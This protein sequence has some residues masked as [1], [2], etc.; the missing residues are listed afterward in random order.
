MKQSREILFFDL[1][2]SLMLMRAF[3]HQWTFTLL[4]FRQPF[5]I[6]GHLFCSLGSWEHAS[7][8]HRCCCQ[9]G[10]T[11]WCP[12]SIGW[13][14]R[15]PSLYFF[16]VRNGTS[17]CLDEQWL[18]R[19]TVPGT[20]SFLPESG[21]LT[22]WECRLASETDS[23]IAANTLSQKPSGGQWWYIC[24][25]QKPEWVIP[26]SFGGTLMSSGVKGQ[27]RTWLT[28]LTVWDARNIWEIT[29]KIKY[30][31]DFPGRLGVKTLPFHC[32][33]ARVRSLVGELR[34]LQAV[35]QKKKKN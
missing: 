3:C 2:H 35:V 4:P 20:G 34:L 25:V 8:Q 23:V 10:Q 21:F 24:S 31:K 16:K 11:W 30:N 27:G 33:G 9:W 15:P 26:S 6:I 32:M 22:L 17:W 29:F 1:C 13:N 12:W 7:Q 28:R 19:D 5:A 18:R 14:W